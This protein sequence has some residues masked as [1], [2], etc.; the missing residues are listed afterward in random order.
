MSDDQTRPR[1]KRDLLR[2]IEAGRAELE[3]AIDSLD[4]RQLTAIRDAQGWVVKDH[5]AHLAAWERSIVFLLQGRPRY[6]GLGVDE[7]TYRTTEADGFDRVNAAIRLQTAGQTL[8]ETLAGF[9]AVHGELLATLD[10]LTDADLLRTYSSF[11]PDE[12]GEE[13]GAPIVGW[14]VGNTYEHYEEH[15]DWIRELLQRPAS[16]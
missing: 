14:I 1:D 12:P 15:L 9:Q 6:E 13:T 3:A 16:A 5:L 7:A 10:G 4:E 8:A 11:A 2:R